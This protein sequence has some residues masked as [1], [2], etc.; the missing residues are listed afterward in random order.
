MMTL[1]EDMRLFLQQM[2]GAVGMSGTARN[3]VP[4]VVLGVALNVAALSLVEN[5]RTERRSTCQK[6]TLQDAAQTEFK[7]MRTVVSSTLKTV[8]KRQP[9]WCGA[10]SWVS[11]LQHEVANSIMEATGLRVAPMG[12]ECA[13]SKQLQ[14]NKSC[15]LRIVRRAA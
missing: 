8:G 9:G 10:R 11:N 6:T 5:T 13:R 4:L 7:V 1:I 12:Y 3:V 2:C 15:G 14:K